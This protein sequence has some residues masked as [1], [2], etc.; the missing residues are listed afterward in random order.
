MNSNNVP[1]RVAQLHIY[2]PQ[3]VAKWEE[4]WD[5]VRVIRSG[6]NVHCAAEGIEVSTSSSDEVSIKFSGSP[7][8]DITKECAE[9]LMVCLCRALGL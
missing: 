6:G 5:G 1:V 8:V 7:A 3:R 2:N 4:L 9:R